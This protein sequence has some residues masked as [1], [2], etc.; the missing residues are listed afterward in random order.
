VYNVLG[1]EVAM[2]F[3]G[4]AQAGEYVSVV[5]NAVNMPS[6]VY[7]ARLQQNDRSMIQQMVLIK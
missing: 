7:F 1:Q 4:I 6:G 5:F 2:L 3:N